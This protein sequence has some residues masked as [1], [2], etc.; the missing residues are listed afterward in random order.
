MYIGTFFI[1]LKTYFGDGYMVVKFWMSWKFCGSFDVTD[2]PIF[3][4]N[5]SSLELLM[6]SVWEKV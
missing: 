2:F 5:V 1:W 3:A 6:K 4:L